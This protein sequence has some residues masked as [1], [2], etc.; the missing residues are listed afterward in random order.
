VAWFV[1]HFVSQC[2]VYDPCLFHH[3]VRLRCRCDFQ[4]A[5]FYPYFEMS[6]C[7]GTH[8]SYCE[9][10]MGFACDRWWLFSLLWLLICFVIW[11]IYACLEVCLSSFNKTLGSSL[12]GEL[13]SL[14]EFD[15]WF[16]FPWT[17]GEYRLLPLRNLEFWS[18]PSWVWNLMFVIHMT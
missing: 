10:W 17:H 12:Q 3:G 16:D 5:G 18:L 7:G 8:F 6:C 4:L 2:F 11:V 14:V 1:C 15:A 9:W 13:A